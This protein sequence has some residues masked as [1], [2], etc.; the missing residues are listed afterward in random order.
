[1]WKIN[2]S[3]IFFCLQCN[4]LNRLL[5]CAHKKNCGSHVIL[6]CIYKNRISHHR[7]NNQMQSSSIQSQISQLLWRTCPS[8]SWTLGFLPRRY[9]IAGELRPLIA[10]FPRCPSRNYS[11]RKVLSALASFSLTWPIPP[12]TRRKGLSLL[13]LAVSPK[14]PPLS[15]SAT[16]NFSFESIP[17]FFLI[18]S[19]S[20]R[21]QLLPTAANGRPIS[22][23]FDWDTC[24]ISISLCGCCGW[25][26]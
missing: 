9:W 11:S 7:T 17:R 26:F 2:L 14:H 1:M 12:K 22:S 6:S 18:S 4:H 23:L 10:T 5:Q 21:S 24:D 16:I 25:T 13:R 8:S 15:I 20:L 3:G 19:Q